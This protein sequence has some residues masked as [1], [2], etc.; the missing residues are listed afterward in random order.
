MKH[1][2]TLILSGNK[3]KFDQFLSES[4]RGEESFVFLS[5]LKEK[6]YGLRAGTFMAIGTF[7]DREDAREMIDL[8]RQIIKIK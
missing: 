3:K 7:F 1:Q 5:P 2:K 4:G 8:A 6:Y